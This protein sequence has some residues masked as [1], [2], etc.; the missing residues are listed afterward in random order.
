MLHQQDFGRY[1]DVYANV[2]FLFYKLF[3][4]NYEVIQP[5]YAISIYA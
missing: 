4:Q 5:H 3:E 1:A 2:L